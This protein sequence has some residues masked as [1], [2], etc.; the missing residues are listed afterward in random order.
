MWESNI[1]V[2]GSIKDKCLWYAT[3]LIWLWKKGQNFSWGIS[4]LGLWTSVWQ[5]NLLVCFGK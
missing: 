2:P 3:W 4:C 1:A 5:W